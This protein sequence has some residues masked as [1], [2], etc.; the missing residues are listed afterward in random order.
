MGS[1]KHFFIANNA[2]HNTT[3]G[4]WFGKKIKVIFLLNQKKLDGQ[5]ESLFS[6][7]GQY[8]VDIVFEKEIQSFCCIVNDTV[9]AQLRGMR[10]APTN[11]KDTLMSRTN[12]NTTYFKSK[13][14]TIS[15]KRIFNYCAY[16]QIRICGE[17]RY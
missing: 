13:H 16:I 17:S 11:T 6:R 8:Y 14:K 3:W 1:K 15:I 5:A 7:N 10:P 4:V 2:F 9:A 12:S